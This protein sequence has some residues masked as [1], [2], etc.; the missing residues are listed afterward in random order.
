MLHIITLLGLAALLPASLSAGPLFDGHLH[1]NSTHAAH[2]SPQQIIEKLACNGI[3][4]AVV[5]GTPASHTASLY[6]QAPARI[7]PLLGIYRSPDDKITWPKDAS[8]P[9]RIEATL[10]TGIWRGIGELHIFASDRHS[11]VFRRIIELAAQH[12]LPV[13]IH[14]DPAVIDTVYDIAASQAVIWAH[15]GTFPYPDLVADY[16]QRYPALT[17]DLSV[18]D[19][20]IAPDGEIS[21]DWYELFVRF[22]DRF[23]V[24]VDTYSL[25]RWQNF[26]T[27]VAT[28]RHWLAQLPDE[29]ARRLAHD[30]AARLF[31]T[32]GKTAEPGAFSSMLC[33][34]STKPE[35]IDKN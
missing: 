26:D 20:R 23:I 27:A 14:G 1:Y 19:E 5:S 30:N 34:A 12:R 22:P 15:A 32:T 31:G 13:Q 7:V 18:R 2:Y 24:G 9:A 33:S 17:V 3:R 21:D 8:L 4:H 11:P 16:L 29:V 10:N 6:R 28:L 25:A 35:P